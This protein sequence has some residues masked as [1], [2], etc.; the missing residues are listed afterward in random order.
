MICQVRIPVCTNLPRRTSLTDN[1]LG[2]N[3]TDIWKLLPRLTDY[4][5]V[6]KS[7]IHCWFVS[8]IPLSSIFLVMKVQA[9][10]VCCDACNMHN[11]IYVTLAGNLVATSLL[12]RVFLT[13]TFLILTVFT[14]LVLI[15]QLGIFYVRNDGKISELETFECKL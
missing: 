12:T 2:S 4:M 10:N 8:M 11:N 15:F 13:M 9:S 5:S 1:L 6:V 3:L 14:R 7:P